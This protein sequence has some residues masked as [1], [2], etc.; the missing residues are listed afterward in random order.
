MKVLRFGTFDDAKM[1]LFC[2]R[3]EIQLVPDCPTRLF[4]KNHIGVTVYLLNSLILGFLSDGYVKD[5]LWVLGYNTFYANNRLALFN[6]HRLVSMHIHTCVKRKKLMHMPFHHV[7]VRTAKN[8][9][10]G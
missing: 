1:L 7:H 3:G 5:I 2:R 8:L 9:K 4:S 6:G 10:N